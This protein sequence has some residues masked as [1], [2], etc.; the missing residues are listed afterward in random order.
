MVLRHEGPYRSRQQESAHPLGHRYG[1]QCGRQYGPASPLAWPG[2][3]GLGRSGVPGADGRDSPRGPAGA[4][5]HEPPSPVS[6]P[7]RCGGVGEE[8]HQIAR[9]G[10]RWNMSS[11]SSN[12]SSGSRRS[13]TAAWPRM[14]IGCWSPVRSR[15]CTWSAV[16]PADGRLSGPRASASAET[17]LIGTPGAGRAVPP[18]GLRPRGRGAHT[19]RITNQHCSEVP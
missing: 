2:D 6:R 17:R 10:P 12:A 13:A 7:P 4:G 3:A 9:S 1:G 19:R 8:P 15:I 5:F 16:A 18:T 14:P 11:A